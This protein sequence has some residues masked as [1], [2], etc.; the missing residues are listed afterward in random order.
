MRDVLY[1]AVTSNRFEVAILLVITCNMFLMMIQHY[2]QSQQVTRALYILD[3][4]FEQLEIFLRVY[5][6]FFYCF[7]YY[8]MAAK[9]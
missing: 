8:L 1:D 5:V 6:C 4:V 9:L 2:G 7:I 3:G